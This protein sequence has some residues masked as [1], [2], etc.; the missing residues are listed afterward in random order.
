MG[1]GGSRCSCK[2]LNGGLLATVVFATTHEK[3]ESE[4]INGICQI[5]TTYVRIKN[6]FNCI[7]REIMYTVHV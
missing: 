7:C 5:C 3:V 4:I 6:D 2:K 1:P